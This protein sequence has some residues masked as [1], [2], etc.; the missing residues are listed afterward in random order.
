[1]LTV[2][3]SSNAFLV[4]MELCAFSLDKQPGDVQELLHAPD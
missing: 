3:Y 2:A 1:M 4:A